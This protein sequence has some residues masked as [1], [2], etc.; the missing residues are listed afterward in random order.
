MDLDWIY[1]AQDKNEMAKS[2]NKYGHELSGGGALKNC[3]ISGL[4]E[5]L[6]ACY[7]YTDNV[8]NIV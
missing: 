3:E 5:E 6:V 1:L 7:M 4:A 2:C 8:F